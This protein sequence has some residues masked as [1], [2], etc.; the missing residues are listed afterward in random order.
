MLVFLLQDPRFITRPQQP[1]PCLVLPC[2]VSPAPHAVWP[3]LVLEQLVMSSRNPVLW[4]GLA[5]TMVSTETQPQHP[6]LA[7]RKCSL[8]GGESLASPFLGEENHVLATRR[9]FKHFPAPLCS[10][11]TTILDRHQHARVCGR[12]CC[13]YGL[14]P[15]LQNPAQRFKSPSALSDANWVFMSCCAALV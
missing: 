10:L 6:T 2:A 13:A 11:S 12:G 7:V 14:L 9:S 15:A 3:N 8:R 1:P 4:A 5:W